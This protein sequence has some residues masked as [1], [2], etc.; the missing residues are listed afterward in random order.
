MVW[1][2][3][4]L[5]WLIPFAG[6]AQTSFNTYPISTSYSEI[7]MARVG[8]LNND[9]IPDIAMINTGGTYAIAVLRGDGTPGDGGWAEVNVE[10]ISN[11][12]SGRAIFIGDLNADGAKDIAVSEISGVLG[13]VWYRNSGN[14]TSFSRDQGYQTGVISPYVLLKDYNK[15]G[16]LD[17]FSIN[18][19]DNAITI[20]KNDPF[21]PG[22]FP[23]PDNYE[24]M[25]PI[26]NPTSL[27]AGDIDLDGDIDVIAVGS[28]SDGSTSYI[29]WFERTGVNFFDSHQIRPDNQ[30][31][32]LGP[33]HV[34]LVDVNKDGWLDAIV[35]SLTADRLTVLL[36][37][38]NP[39]AGLWNN[40][41]VVDAAADGCRSVAVA[42][43]DGDGDLDLVAANDGGSEFAWYEND[44]SLSFTKH[45]LGT[46]FTGARWVDVADMDDDGDKDI[47]GTA[48]TSGLVFFENMAAEHQTIA[49]NGSGTF[50]GGKV[51]ISFSNDADP[52]DVSVYFDAGN[53][54][55]RGD[56]DPASG[57]DHLAVTGY[58]YL[59]TDKT[60]FTSTLVFS[61]DN[62]PGWTGITSEQ[63]LR[64]AHFNTS[65]GQ[66]ELAGTGQTVDDVNNTI[67]VTGVTA[68]SPFT[69][70]ST[71]PDN[72]LPVTLISLAGMISGNEMIIRW[73]TSSETD[74]AGYQLWWSA[75]GADFR[76]LDSYLSNPK[77]R[78]N[79]NSSTTKK[80]EV[81]YSLPPV[82][83]DEIIIRWNAI[84]IEGRVDLSRTLRIR[85]VESTDQLAESFQLNSCY[86]NPFNPVVYIP[87]QIV[88]AEKKDL[89][90]EIYNLQGQKVYTLAEK[91]TGTGDY[92][93]SW[94]GTNEFGEPVQS[95]MYFLRVR[96][97]DWVKT[98]KI[99]LM[100]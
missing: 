19:L 6:M 91:G 80:Y 72:S 85:R 70:A 46:T 97:G 96:Y 42:D 3:L 67:T 83:G 71:T 35:A 40:E 79:G 63:N 21:D 44:G 5:L 76:L 25:N 98:Q 2:V 69:L 81:R 74:L 24:V 75:D 53:V 62:I 8:D 65:S 87:V 73:E 41:V 55:D 49:Q 60:S 29:Y 7:R 92:L 15:D 89:V 36:N 84:S 10:T 43:L 27:D 47:I 22:T 37:D 26:S 20:D 77:L 28:T 12:S 34:L 95:G 1:I 17:I 4:V 94:D 18:Y 82:A 39:K 38:G 68:F 52:G 33:L 51:Q 78:V 66:W 9:G 100:K 48:L 54:P 57:L 16:Y 56:I 59:S 14:G 88:S 45:S 58:Y 90:V 32:F 30:P 64:I 61:Y 31:A 99:V 50:A 11:F 13:V 86:P 23:F 93:F